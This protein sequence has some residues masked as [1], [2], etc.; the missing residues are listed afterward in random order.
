MYNVKPQ[1]S[2][3]YWY[4]KMSNLRNWNQKLSGFFRVHLKLERHDGFDFR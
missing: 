4:N 2:I 3:E 1:P